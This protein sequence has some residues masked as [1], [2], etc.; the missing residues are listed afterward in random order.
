MGSVAAPVRRDGGTPAEAAADI[1]DDLRKQEGGEELADHGMVSGTA[2]STIATGQ[3]AHREGDGGEA[4]ERGGAVVVG[5]AHG[6]SAVGRSALG[7]VMGEGAT[8]IDEV[9]RPVARLV[10]E[11]TPVLD[12]VPGAVAHLVGDVAGDAQ[13]GRVDVVQPGAGPGVDAQVVLGGQV[14]E[15]GSW[16]RVD[17]HEAILEVA[18]ERNQPAHEVEVALAMVRRG[19]VQV[20]FNRPQ[21]TADETEQ[22][23]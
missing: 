11:V 1:G 20:E 18:D 7:R 10:D 8:V 5:V 4:E 16:C 19:R 9:S 14:G 17:E 3:P 12:Q 2:G 23:H 6:L 15:H 21:D 22:E 13:P